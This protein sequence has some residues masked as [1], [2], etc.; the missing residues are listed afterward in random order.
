VL[1]FF[2]GLEDIDD[3]ET[4]ILQPVLAWSSKQWTITSWNCCLSGVVTSSPSVKVAPGD[5]IFGS[6]TSTCAAKTLSCKTWNV[7]SVDLTTGKSTILANTPSDAQ[8]FNWAFGGVAEPYYVVS[9]KDF[10]SGE[11]LTF[12]A[13]TLFDENLDPVV[14]PA[15]TPAFD[16]AATPACDYGIKD[17][18]TSVTLEF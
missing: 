17:T 14:K 7:L 9:C 16:S 12:T 8:I 13:I 10:P 2:P 11:G 4:S 5:R 3:S 15:W 6:V 1:F 18:A